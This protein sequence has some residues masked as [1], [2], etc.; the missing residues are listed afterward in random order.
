MICISSYTPSE[1]NLMFEICKF[2]ALISSVAISSVSTNDSSLISL[3]SLN[4]R[5]LIIISIE[6]K[7]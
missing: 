3:N 5:S 1:D 7:D 4:L 2:N 6:L